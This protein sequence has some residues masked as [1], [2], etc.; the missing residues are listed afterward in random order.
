MC[1]RLKGVLSSKKEAERNSARLH[2]DFPCDEVWLTVQ[3]V[4]DD[5][6]DTRKQPDDGGRYET[7]DDEIFWGFGGDCVHQL[8]PTDTVRVPVTNANEIFV[9]SNRQ[10]G[11]ETMVAF[12][13]FEDINREKNQK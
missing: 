12:S 7:T 3:N 2:E 6:E 8:F 9:R 13:C 10:K 1:R 5:N 11:A 4:E